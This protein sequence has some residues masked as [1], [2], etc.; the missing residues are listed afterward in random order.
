MNGC[1]RP[2]ID[3]SSFQTCCLRPMS[4]GAGSCSHARCSTPRVPFESSA[5][6][7]RCTKQA[8]PDRRRGARIPN[9][10][11]VRLAVTLHR[12]TKPRIRRDTRADRFAAYS[13]R[14]RGL[15][16]PG[17]PIESRRLTAGTRVFAT[18]P[19]VRPRRYRE[20]I[21]AAPVAGSARGRRL[22]PTRHRLGR[23]RGRGGDRKRVP[24]LPAPGLRDRRCA[25]LRRARA[26]PPSA[27]ARTEFLEHTLAVLCAL[28]SSHSGSTAALPQWTDMLDSLEV[29]CRNPLLRTLISDVRLQMAFFIRPFVDDFSYDASLRG[30]AIL[31]DG[32]RDNDALIAVE[33]YQLAWRCLDAELG[34][35][36]EARSTC[37]R[38]I[39]SGRS[40]AQRT[41]VSQLEAGAPW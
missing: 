33:G 39:A 23:R 34:R 7:A 40:A 13:S 3:I 27:D 16:A 18:G 1:V 5:T 10:H 8:L 32:I 25:V 4:W 9:R 21:R 12:A 41:R 14:H 20:G 29:R 35:M 17:S 15:P 36:A 30:L 38:E 11:R 24:C 2:G 37:F 26:V 22:D 28:E 19:C 6:K 31:G